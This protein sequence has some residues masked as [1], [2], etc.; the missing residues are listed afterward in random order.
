MYIYLLS[1]TNS[2]NSVDRNATPKC[3]ASKRHRISASSRSETCANVR[4]ERATI[5]WLRRNLRRVIG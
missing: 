3:E 1:C 4:C 2:V 5:E